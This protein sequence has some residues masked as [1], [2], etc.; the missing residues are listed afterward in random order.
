MN[1]QNLMAQAQKMQRDMMK[2]KEEL[3]KQ[4]FTGNSELVT[5]VFNG[6]KE[7]ISVDIKKES[8]DVDDVEILEDMIKIAINNS[9]TKVAKATDDVMG[10]LGGMGGL[11]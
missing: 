1:M 11:F 4:E 7:L 9:L 6:N 5:V 8:Y 2:K 10:D 3:S